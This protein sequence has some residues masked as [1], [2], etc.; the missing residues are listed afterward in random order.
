MTIICI[1]TRGSH[2]EGAQQTSVTEAL[3]G[4]KLPHCS[5]FL[6]SGVLGLLN[7]VG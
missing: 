1:V 6:K 3:Q 7:S 5:Q 2:S 4:Q